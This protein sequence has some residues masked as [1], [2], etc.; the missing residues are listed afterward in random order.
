MWGSY[1]NNRTVRTNREEGRPNL[2]IVNMLLGRSQNDLDVD[3][4][5]HDLRRW[6]GEDKRV[7]G[8]GDANMGDGGEG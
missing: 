8:G 1:R 7:G 3:V 2:S 5:F 6:G 4:G